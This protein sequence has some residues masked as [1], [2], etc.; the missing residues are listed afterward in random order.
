VTG[1]EICS[2]TRSGR[3]SRW[4]RCAGVVGSVVVTAIA[5]SVLPFVGPVGADPLATAK[6]QAAALAQQI[7][8]QG[9]RLAALSEQY[10]QAQL[11]VQQLDARLSATRA[12]VAQAQAQVGAAQ[13][14]LRRQA[15][16]AYMSGGANTGLEQVFTSGG[17]QS[18]AAQEYRAVAGGNVSGA[19]DHLNQ[20]QATLAQEQSQL[21]ATEQSARDAL[22][23]ADAAK[24]G[25]AAAL[26]GQQATLSHVKGQIATLVAQQQAAQAAAQAAAFQAQLAAERARQ[27]SSKS[28]S[29]GLVP[30]PPAAGGAGGKAVSAAESQIG[31]P[32][33]YGGATP[34]VGFDCSGLTMWAWEQA[35]VSLSHSAAAQYGETTHI[36]L[37]DLQPGDLLF[38][39]EGGTIGHV[40]MYV[41]PGEMIQAE[42]TG[43]RIQITGIWSTGLV[44]A[45]RP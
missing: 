9:Q 31:V 30:A 22:G 35:G 45:G 24:R 4:P 6:A 10:D 17:E 11:R 26:A 44:G 34:G 38:Y 39:Y 27:A 19:I 16:D 36:P 5:A 33:V 12:A 41:G 1:V 25:S 32:Y 28:T 29:V 37:S 13:A 23:Q 43:T 18:T 21:Q 8:A 20:V 3:R 14:D 40:T 2:T 42:E 7:Q 15:L